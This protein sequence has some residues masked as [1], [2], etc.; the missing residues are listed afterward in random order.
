MEVG[1]VSSVWANSNEEGLLVVVSVT[2][3]K[4]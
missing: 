3:E 2:A 1:W 4:E